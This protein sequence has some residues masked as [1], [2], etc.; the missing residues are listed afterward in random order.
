MLRVA[1]AVLGVVFSLVMQVT[2]A[3]AQAPYEPNDSI[4]QAAGPLVGGSGLS[5][6]L[7]TTNDYDWYRVHLLGG[8]QVQIS[9]ND[10]SCSDG[11]PLT[12]FYDFWGLEVENAYFSPF[13]WTTPYAGGTFYLAVFQGSP[14]C[15]TYRLQVN[16]ASAVVTSE[17]PAPTPGTWPETNEDDAHATGPL[18]GNVLYSGGQETTNDSDNAFFF[19]VPNRRLTI[20]ITNATPADHGRDV[21]RPGD[22]YRT[23][24]ACTLANTLKLP[25]GAKFE[26]EAPSSSLGTALEAN[27]RRTYTIGGGTGGRALLSLSGDKPRCRWQVLMTPADALSPTPVST[28]STPS[29]PSNNQSTGKVS[30]RCRAARKAHSRALIR[31]RREKLRSRPRAKRLRVLRRSVTKA[32]SNVNRACRK[33]SA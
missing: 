29:G 10:P 27:R 25:A 8:Q 3:R 30:A 23:E 12:K 21:P 9:S 4:G 16:P 19:L 32:R 15:P 20:E 6:V 28:P 14:K 17:S 26:G 5:G 18:S 2:P 7:E 13:N 33:Q 31:Y 22:P 11:A 24:Q 1:I